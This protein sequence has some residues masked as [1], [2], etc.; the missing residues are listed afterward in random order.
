[1]RE[2]ACQSRGLCVLWLDHDHGAECGQPCGCVAHSQP[3][4]PFT[5]EI[6]EGAT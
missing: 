5:P 3:P 1:M 6:A 2:E 4:L